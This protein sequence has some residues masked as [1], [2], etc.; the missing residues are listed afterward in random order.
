MTA[1]VSE[2]FDETEGF[3]SRANTGHVRRSGD[4]LADG[5]L[6]GYE[7]KGGTLTYAFPDS[8]FDYIYGPERNSFGAINADIQDAVRRVLD[9]S[10]SGGTA[11]DAFSVEG[12]TNLAIFESGDHANADL[13]YALSNSADPTAYAYY[14]SANAINDKGRSGDVWYG[15]DYAMEACMTRPLLGAVHSS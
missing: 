11:D 4:K 8:A 6:S 9:G 5:V 1:F 12:F 2:G 14:P 13:R 15:T 10:A 3:I 7:W